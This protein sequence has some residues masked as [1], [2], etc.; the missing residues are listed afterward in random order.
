MAQTQ[1][2]I[3]LAAKDFQ[4]T[5]NQWG[6]TVILKQFDQNFSRQI[7]SAQD[8]DKD[9]GT[10]QIYYCHNVMP[11]SGGFQSIGFFQNNPTAGVNGLG[12]IKTYQNPNG[13]NGYLAFQVVGGTVNVYSCE[14]GNGP[15]VFRQSLTWGASGFSYKVTTA[16]INGSTYIYIPLVGCYQYS[17]ASHTLT[18]TT[19]TGI[20]TTTTIGISDSFGYMLAF[21][22]EFLAWSS[23]VDPTDFTPSLVTGA[24]GG[25]VQDIKTQIYVVTK[26][27]YG[28]TIFSDQNAVAAIYSGNS[29]YPFNFKPIVGAGGCVDNEL[30]GMDSESG[31]LYAWTTNGM[32]LVSIQQG[33]NVF[34]DLTNFLGGNL[35]EDIDDATLTYSLT[36]ITQGL[37]FKRLAVVSGRYLIISY[38]LSELTHA[39][40]YDIGMKRWGKVKITHVNAFDLV[41]GGRLP[42]DRARGALSFLGTD[43][44]VNTVQFILNSLGS[45]SYG[46]LVLG[47]YQ[48]TRNRWMTLEQVAPETILGPNEASIYVIPTYDGKTWQPLVGLKARADSQAQAPIYDCR[49][50]GLNLS[51][52]F[53]GAF[54]LDSC[55][56]AYHPSGRR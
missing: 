19:L 17:E 45:Q 34:P 52:M 43:G 7:V 46:I 4:F 12:Q 55:I 6:R 26:N 51:L 31:N 1:Y 53:V 24:G 56:L 8:P 23:T 20:D 49:V 5:I 27:L 37:L 16:V 15:F 42:S 29:R 22:A 40:V 44:S 21:S 39:L 13:E 10:P 30:V 14:R 38:G 33:Q 9:I 28:V 36:E 50:S 41:Y 25:A 2:R 35:F 48:H 18:P 3:N 47:K 11:S 54:S 32:Q